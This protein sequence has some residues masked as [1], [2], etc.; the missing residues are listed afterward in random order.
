MDIEKNEIKKLQDII[1]ERDNTIAQQNAKI[2][3]L[4]QKLGLKGVKKTE[5][6]RKKETREVSFSKWLD[7]QSK[8]VFP[9]EIRFRDKSNSLLL[10]HPQF[11]HIPSIF[12]FENINPS[13][14]MIK[15]YL[16]IPPCS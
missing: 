8:R 16:G 10:H 14:Q 4:E 3:D 6:K 7:T 1:S 13:R 11:F 15:C 2:A 12:N 9:A 5:P